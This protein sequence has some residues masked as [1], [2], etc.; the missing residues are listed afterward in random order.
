[1]MAFKWMD[2]NWN[3]NS[4]GSLIHNVKYVY[5]K[6]NRRTINYNRSNRKNSID[7]YYHAHTHLNTFLMHVRRRTIAY[8]AVFSTWAT[9]VAVD[10]VIFN[11]NGLIQVLIDMGNYEYMQFCVC[12]RPKSGH[13]TSDGTGSK[14]THSDSLD[15]LVLVLLSIWNANRMKSQDVLH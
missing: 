2:G 11:S 5:V 8:F 15:E 3:V 10:I 13:Y 6:Q 12:V 9:I 7:D 14:L 4:G 1:M